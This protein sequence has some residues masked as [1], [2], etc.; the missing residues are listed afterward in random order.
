MARDAF[1]LHGIKEATA[2]LKRLERSLPRNEVNTIYRRN[3]NPMLRAM[4]QG[5]SSDN[6]AKMTAITTKQSGRSRAP[7]VGIRIGVINNDVNLFPDFSAPALASVLEHGTD[8]RFRNIKSLGI[9][10]SQQSTG[11]VMAKP[12]LRPAYDANE[13]DFIAKTMKSIIKK[14][15][16]K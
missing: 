5:S 4:K 3:A 10:T 16:N 7:K 1:V 6:I 12:W 8:E 14:V 9:I 13:A 11:K 2:E 15:E